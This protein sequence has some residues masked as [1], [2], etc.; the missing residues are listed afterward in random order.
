MIHQILIIEKINIFTFLVSIFISRK[1]KKIMIFESKQILNNFIIHNKFLKKQLKKI[2]KKKILLVNDGTSENLTFFSNKIGL[3][4]VIKSS[5][6]KNSFLVSKINDKN[7][8]KVHKKHILN[9]IQSKCRLYLLT[10]YL[11][12]KYNCTLLESYKD[13]FHLKN[14][15]KLSNHIITYFAFF[16][17]FKFILKNFA[18]IIKCLFTYIFV[19]RFHLND[20]EKHFDLGY[21]L[22]NRG[23]LEELFIN[24]LL[25]KKKSKFVIVNTDWKITKKY[26]VK[27][28]NLEIIK[29]KYNTINIFFFWKIIKYFLN[30]IIKL[31]KYNQIENYISVKILID[32]FN[33]EIFCQ[34]YRIKNFISRDDYWES[35]GVRTIVQNKYNLKHS[36][37][38]HSAF[39]K[40][41]GNSYICF[42][43]FDTYFRYNKFNFDSYKNYS[44]SKINSIV[45]NFTSENILKHK[46]SKK[47]KIFD[48]KYSNKKNIL[49][50]PPPLFGNSF[51]N[52]TELFQKLK[53]LDKILSNYKNINIFISIRKNLKKDINILFKNYPELNQYKH[54]IFFNEEFNTQELINYSDII[55]TGD[56]STISL[57]ILNYDPNKILCVANFRFSKKKAIPWFDINERIIKQTSSE[58]YNFIEIAIEKP[59]LL[60]NE[61]KKILINDLNLGLNN[62]TEKII[63]QLVKS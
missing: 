55:I 15:F 60:I 3:D 22:S 62:I 2:L 48:E 24:K 1:Y 45:G 29:F 27:L 12:K 34:H 50:I 10:R 39:I 58:I 9:F 28:S 59:Q 54:R 53:F 31:F 63:N 52:Y 21:Q 56:T 20:K 14:K 19:N 13:Y 43:Y 32:Y 57:E 4:Y 18:K 30:L 7:I 11:C 25:E 35:H 41:F 8:D 36:G 17:D 16:E 37:I 26:N 23:D 61:Q 40:S 5:I 33:Q 6:T 47:K 38:Q 42:D 51:V 46:G 44:F 49:I